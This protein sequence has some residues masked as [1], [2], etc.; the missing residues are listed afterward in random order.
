[1]KHIIK[2]WIWEHEN[3]PDFPYDREKLSEKLK[4]AQY[5]RGLVSG[6]LCIANK[7][8]FDEL[9]ITNLTNEIINTFQIEGEYL[10]RDSVRDSVAKAIN[11]T[12][13]SSEDMSTRHTDNLVSL[14]LDS[15]RNNELLSVTR[16]HAWHNALFANSGGYEDVKKINIAQF[17]DY[18]D[19]KVIEN[20]FNRA[21]GV[22]KYLAPPYRLLEK[23]I[24]ALI[25]YC[26]QSDEDPYIKSA[27]AHLWFV[28]IHPYDDGNGRISRAIADYILSRDL[29]EEHKIY[30]LSATIYTKRA[31]YYEIL[32]MTTNLHKNRH[33]DFTNWIEWNIDIL[34]STL[35]KAYEDVL[36]IVK[37]AKFWDRCKMI[38]L[39]K[40]HTLFLDDFINKLSRGGNSEFSNVNYREIT[41]TIPM[42]ANRQI[43][44]LL[45]YGLIAK[46]EGKAG[47]STCYRILFDTGD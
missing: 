4:R 45:E 39:S 28:S 31:E 7:D 41:N 14:M 26:N 38:N 18:D 23:D 42:T 9:E 17:R 5:L 47:R 1:M 8:E 13:I 20:A 44:K 30:S 6:V 24:N 12:Y 10:H 2:K 16:L 33:F 22:V 3:Y 36:F 27:L 11:Q 43:K 21:G 37:K 34:I 40:G 19:M 29:K 35:E 15:H 46:V 25:K 32:D